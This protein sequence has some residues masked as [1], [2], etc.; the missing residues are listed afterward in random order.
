VDL[1]AQRAIAAR[2]VLVEPTPAD[3][4]ADAKRQ[5]GS[6]ELRAD[7]IEDVEDLVGAQ[8]R[9]AGHRHGSSV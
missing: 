2:Q 4:H 6:F 1:T 3:D 9:D 5:S 8:R 7:L